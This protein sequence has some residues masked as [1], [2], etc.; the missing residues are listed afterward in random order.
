MSFGRLVLLAV[1]AVASASDVCTRVKNGCGECVDT[2]S[3]GPHGDSCLWCDVLNECRM[4]NEKPAT[5]CGP[6]ECVRSPD[7]GGSSNCTKTA[8]IG[9]TT[10]QGFVPPP[11]PGPPAPGIWNPDCTCGSYC[12][13]KCSNNESKSHRLTTYRVTPFNAPGILNMNTA[14]PAGDIAFALERKDIRVECE[15]NPSGERCFLAHQNIYGRFEIDWDGKWGP[16]QFCNPSTGSDGQPNVSKFDCCASFNHDNPGECVDMPNIGAFDPYDA[17]CA[18]HRGNVSVGRVDHALMSHHWSNGSG[19]TQTLGG[20]WYST[21]GDGECTGDEK[22][23]TGKRGE[24]TW[25]VATALYKNTSCVDGALDAAVEAHHPTCFKACPAKT[26][27]AYDACYLDC[28]FESLNGNSTLKLKAMTKEAIVKPWVKAMAS[29][30]VT[31]GG[32]LPCVGTPPFAL[33]SCP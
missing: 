12:D 29:T 32:C 13:Y 14:D 31:V 10:C 7:G 16:Y 6:D 11:P 5:G 33:G 9:G 3:G 15:R 2:E 18:C 25:K 17:A 20:Y 26:D 30:N 19:Y 27:P 4:W 23:G 24:C 8:G 28:F 22:P 21:P 1:A